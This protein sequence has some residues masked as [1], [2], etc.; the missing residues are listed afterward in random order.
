MEKSAS[1]VTT[2]SNTEITP[3]RG[4]FDDTF[5]DGLFRTLH[6]V[7]VTADDF[8]C[9]TLHYSRRARGKWIRRSKDD[10]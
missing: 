1:D 8:L 3:D 6:R 10:S 9:G 2:D 7:L 5:W 4:R